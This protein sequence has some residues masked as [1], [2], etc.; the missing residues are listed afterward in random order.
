MKNLTADQRF[1]RAATAALA[2]LASCLATAAGTGREIAFVGCPILRNTELPCWLGESG[3]ELYYLGPQGDL[4]SQFYPP[5]FDHRMLVE[6]VVS[7]QAR[8]CGGLV[9][10]PVKVSVLPQVDLTCNVTLPAMGYPDPPHERGPGPSGTRGVVPPPYPRPTPVAYSAPF[11]AQTF[12]VPFDAGSERPWNPAQAII[13]T[14]ARYAVASKA[15][16]IH[17]T[18]YRAAFKLSQGGEYAEPEDLA[19]RRAKM[20]EQGLRTLDLP[21]G[22]Q[23]IVDW[24]QDVVHVSGMDAGSRARRVSIVVTPSARNPAVAQTAPTQDR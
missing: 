12:L 3:G 15:A 6:G 18:G 1:R 5:Q 9:L 23:L 4:T 10:K 17:V 8:I 2:L 11:A 13:Q 14:A 19:Q 22:T 16:S 24:K 7:D 21:A 20:V